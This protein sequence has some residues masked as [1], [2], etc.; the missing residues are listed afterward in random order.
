MS[1]RYFLPIAALAAAVLVAACGDSPKQADGIVTLTTPTPPVPPIPALTSGAVGASPRGIGVAAATVFTFG[2][3]TSPAG[4]VP[5]YTF[6]WKF[7]DGAEGAGDTL[8]HT[9]MAT[10]DFT[11]VVTVTDSKGTKATASTSVQ[12]RN[13]TGRWTATI[14]GGGSGLD[15]D[16]INLIQDGTAVSATVNSTN[17]FG[18]GEGVGAVANPRALNVGVSFTAPP[19]P[20]PTPV[21]PPINPFAASYRGTMDEALLTWTGTVTGYPGCPCPFVA[22]RPSNTG[23]STGQDRTDRWSVCRLA[24]TKRQ[25]IVKTEAE[26]PRVFANDGRGDN[27]QHIVVGLLRHLV[28]VA[29]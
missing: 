8:V 21:T 28:P 16:R 22:T 17:G 14:S 23:S 20:P 9:Y 13:I 2:Y 27:R 6:A 29:L 4:G 10:G 7:G 19:P 26:E 11:V 12:V 24:F 1:V 18:L 5:P 25:R 3:A 15:A